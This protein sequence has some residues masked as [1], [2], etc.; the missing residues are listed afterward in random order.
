MPAT[1]RAFHWEG[2]RPARLAVGAPAREPFS[3]T[4]WEKTQV[5]REWDNDAEREMNPLASSRF[6]AG[7]TGAECRAG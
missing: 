2:G 7:E 3:F 1:G 5:H 6:Q 4:R